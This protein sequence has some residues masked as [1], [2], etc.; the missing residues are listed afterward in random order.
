MFDS[1]LL[2]TDHISQKT[3]KAYSILGIIK[4]SFIYMDEAT[5]IQL[6]YTNHG[7]P[8]LRICLLL[9]LLDSQNGPNAPDSTLTLS[10]ALIRWE[11]KRV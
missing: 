4:R 8:T 1:N 11:H 3:N 5:F 9:L 6:Y 7:S 10:G 2:F